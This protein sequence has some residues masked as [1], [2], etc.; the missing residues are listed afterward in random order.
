MKVDVHRPGTKA[1]TPEDSYNQNELIQ[2]LAAWTAIPTVEALFIRYQNGKNDIY[3]DSRNT[4]KYAYPPKI[5]RNCDK[6][7]WRGGNNPQS[8]INLIGHTHFGND[9]LPSQDDLNATRLPG[10]DNVFYWN[11]TF[12]KF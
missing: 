9:S 12:R 5:V 10:V 11:G 6:Y 8:P 3:I 2:F 7:Y 4:I 1:L